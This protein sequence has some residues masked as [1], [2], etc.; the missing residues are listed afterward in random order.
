MKITFL[1]TG[2]GN[3]T[4]RAH[5]GMALECPDGTKLL[6]DT[7]SGNSALR[8]AAAVGLELKEF[9]DVLLSHDHPD[10]MGGIDFIEFNRALS[11]E[12]YGPLRVHASY[13]ALEGLKRH[14]I[15]T[16]LN[17]RDISGD[18]RA[19]L[20]GP[21]TAALAARRPRAGD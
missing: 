6:L 2:A 15:T 21:R 11:G 19:Q 10:H 1:G 16:R 8:S 20:R 4:L 18:F 13:E 9:E 12:Q 14:S 3:S 17:I 5:T 7:S